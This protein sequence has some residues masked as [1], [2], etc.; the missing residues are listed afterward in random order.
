MAYN[1][2][3]KYQEDAIEKIIVKTKDIIGCGDKISRDE[4]VII[5]K[6]PTGSGKTFTMAEYI[7]QIIKEWV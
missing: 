6:A 4:K 1:E 5:F 3:K 7:C 2:L